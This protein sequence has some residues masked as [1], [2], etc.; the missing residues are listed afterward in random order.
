MVI[1][2]LKNELECNEHQFAS[3]FWLLLAILKKPVSKRKSGVIIQC[4]LSISASLGT[5]ISHWL[6]KTCRSLKTF[7][8]L[9]FLPT[10]WCNILMKLIVPEIKIITITISFF[11]FYMFS[12]VYWQNM[13]DKL[14]YKLY[15]L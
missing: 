1:R 13:N 2:L 7:K 5:V 6:L 12:I 14:K 10:H 4:E 15:F 3:E 8:A 11:S 9:V